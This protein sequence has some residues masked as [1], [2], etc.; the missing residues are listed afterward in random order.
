MAT[1]KKDK[2]SGYFIV[3]LSSLELDAKLLQAID[4]AIADAVREEL[5]KSTDV[6]GMSLLQLPIGTLG[7]IMR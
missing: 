6:E 1:G 7:L 2:L 4:R 3:D 5:A